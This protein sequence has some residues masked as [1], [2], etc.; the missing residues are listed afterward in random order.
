[1]IRK[2]NASSKMHGESQQQPKSYDEGNIRYF[3]KMI[4]DT[5]MDEKPKQQRKEYT[6]DN[7]ELSTSEKIVEILHRSTTYRPP[8]TFLPISIA[9]VMVAACIG[10]SL[11]A[12]CLY[13]GS[14]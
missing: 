5:L 9:V 1:M 3:F 4:H 11:G 12:L 7:G 10:T 13:I 14:R 2:D 8:P 6:R